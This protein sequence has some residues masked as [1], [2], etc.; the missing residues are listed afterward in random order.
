MVKALTGKIYLSFK[1]PTR[2]DITA[3]GIVPIDS[4]TG[5]TPNEGGTQRGEIGLLLR[6]VP[7]D[8]IM[9][10]TAIARKLR[11]M[12]VVEEHFELEFVL[13]TR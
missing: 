6:P 5:C 12:V 9:N 3:C 8:D 7:P 1:I 11:L 4:G 2:V 10:I 13:L